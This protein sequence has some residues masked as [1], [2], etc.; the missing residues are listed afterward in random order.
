MLVLVISAPG[1]AGATETAGRL[2]STTTLKTT[3][4]LSPSTGLPRHIKESA[5]QLV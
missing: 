1:A 2:A 5:H 3:K 4:S